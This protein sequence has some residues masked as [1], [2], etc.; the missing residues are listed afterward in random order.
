MYDAI[1]D[2]ASTVW[3]ALA[4]PPTV[5]RALRTVG[6]AA[7]VGGAMAAGTH[8]SRGPASMGGSVAR[9]APYGRRGSGGG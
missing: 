6:T 5:S 1:A 3:R 2:R 4:C 9:C 8:P 7:I